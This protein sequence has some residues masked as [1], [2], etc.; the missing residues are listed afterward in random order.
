MATPLADTDIADVSQAPA[1]LG[2]TLVLAAVAPRVL[3]RRRGWGAVAVAAVVGLA[4]AFLP[5]LGGD[6]FVAQAL[7]RF[8]DR[9]GWVWQL[10]GGVLAAQVLSD[11]AERGRAAWPLLGCG[12]VDAFLVVGL[13]ARQGTQL[14]EVPSVYAAS[15]TP[16]L[17]L[18]PD[19]SFRDPRWTLWTTN[20]DCFYQTQHHRPIADHCIFTPDQPSPRITRSQELVESLLRA[21]PVSVEPPLTLVL[22]ADAFRPH[23]RAALMEG[24]AQLDPAPEESTDGGEW[25]LAYTVR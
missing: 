15:D 13:P 7:L 25:L 20:V 8:P 9:L 5:R 11:L 12:L 6:G 24:L 21:E 1:I 3:R 16:V 17:D 4:L 22:H 14:G 19:G 2:T 23:E 18:W 10:C